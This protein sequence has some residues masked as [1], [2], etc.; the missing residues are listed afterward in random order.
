[1]AA[2]VL[3]VDDEAIVAEMYRLALERTGYRVLIAL[4]GETALETITAARPD[5]IF[6]DVRMPK[7]SGVEVLTR[8]VSDPMTRNIPVVM[9]SNYDD[10]TIVRQSL[11]LGAKE[12]LVKAGMLP[13]ALPTVVAHWLTPPASDELLSRIKRRTTHPV[14]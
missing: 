8:L 4:D 14:S 5:F 12:Y 7:M 13:A 11:S 10:P 2:T 6:L 9:L 1:M 3:V